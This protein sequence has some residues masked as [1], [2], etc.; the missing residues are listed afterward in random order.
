MRKNIDLYIRALA[1]VR[2]QGPSNFLPPCSA[3]AS[4]ARYTGSAICFSNLKA[5]PCLLTSHG[6]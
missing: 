6:E 3:S 5:I 2:T 4:A 1:E